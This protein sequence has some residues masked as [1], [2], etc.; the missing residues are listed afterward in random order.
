MN[1]PQHHAERELEA[2]VE[3]VRGAPRQEDQSACGHEPADLVAAP[4][5]EPQARRERHDPGAQDRRPR[6]HHHQVRAHDGT[7]DQPLRPRAGAGRAGRDE[8]DPR[9][10][11][12]V[13]AGDRQRMREPGAP[14]LVLEAAQRRVA[15]AAKEQVQ[16][17]RVAHPGT[18]RNPR[19]GLRE[20]RQQPRLGARS[21]ALAPRQE[22]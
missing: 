9:Q 8:R 7:Y 19:S 3:E 6:V 16:Q 22:S 11:R 14:H 18:V 15:P 1:E 17:Q 12:Q 2:G 21:Q 10:H 5:G 20:V 13:H 4:R